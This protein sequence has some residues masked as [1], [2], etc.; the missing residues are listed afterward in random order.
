MQIQSQKQLKCNFVLL[1]IN[2]NCFIRYD[3][4]TKDEQ[5]YAEVNERVVKYIDTQ[6]QLSELGLFRSIGYDNDSIENFLFFAE[7]YCVANKEERTR[8]KKLMKY[9]VDFNS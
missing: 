5:G 9:A 8:R 2:A 1:L 3:A 6:N 4:W 7:N